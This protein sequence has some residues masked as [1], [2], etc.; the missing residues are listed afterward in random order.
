M[1]NPI[2]RNRN[3]GTSKQGYKPQSKFQIPSSWYDSRAFYEKLGKT[4]KVIKDINGQKITFIVEAT[5]K[6]SYHACTIEDIEKILWNIS[7]KYYEGLTTIILRQPKAKEEIFSS[8]WGRLIYLYELENKCEPALILEAVDFTKKIVW[9]RKLSV[10]SQKEL[11]RLKEDG[12]NI[13]EDKRKYTFNLD[14]ATVRNTQLYRTLLHEIGHYYQYITTSS[15]V[16]KSLITDEKEAFA[17]NFADKLKMELMESKIIPFDRI[18]KKE[19]IDNL[20]LDISDFEF[21]TPLSIES[22]FGL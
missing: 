4:F 1:N 8:V 16:Y 2:R 3:I 20:K 14:I 15:H 7:R 13:K 19:N 21:D 17:H 18:L 10:D 11:N 9:D 5:K 22:K 6:S 12:F